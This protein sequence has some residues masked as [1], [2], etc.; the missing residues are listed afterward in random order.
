MLLPINENGIVEVPIL[1][2]GDIVEQEEAEQRLVQQQCLQIHLQL[3]VEPPAVLTF[4]QYSQTSGFVDEYLTLQQWRDKYEN[5]VAVAPVAE[6]AAAHT[7]MKLDAMESE[8]LARNH[9]EPSALISA[10]VAMS[11]ENAMNTT[12]AM[13]PKTVNGNATEA[14]GASNPPVDVNVRPHDANGPRPQDGEPSPPAD[15]KPA[16][17]DD[18]KTLRPDEKKIQTADRLWKNIPPP[19]VRNVPPMYRSTVQ[20]PAINRPPIL[21]KKPLVAPKAAANFPIAMNR[22]RPMTQRDGAVGN[23]RPVT[24]ARPNGVPSNTATRLA[25]RSKTMM[26]LNKHPVTHANAAK[27]RECDGPTNAQRTHD[28]RTEP[29]TVSTVDD[30]GWLTVKTRRRTSWANRFNQPSGYASLPTL[31]LLDEKDGQANGDGKAANNKRENKKVVKSA[32]QKP[33]PT[34]SPKSSTD[35]V[36]KAVDATAKSEPKNVPTK[37]PTDTTAAKRVDTAKQAAPSNKAKPAKCAESEK[38]CASIVSRAT[39]LQRQKSDITGL[40]INTLRK[41][42]MRIEKSKNKQ[43]DGKK[44]LPKDEDE[45]VE[46]TAGLGAAENGADDVK[47]D[48]SDL[49]LCKDIDTMDQNDMTDMDH[50]LND[51]VELESDENQRKL[52]EEQMCLERQILELQNSEIE[53]DTDDADC[54]TILGIEES[55]SNAAELE[56]ACDTFLDTCEEH[57]LETKYRHL[58]SDLSSGERIQTLATLQAFVSRYPGRAQELHQKLSSPSRRRSLHESLKKYQVKQDRAQDMRET[59]SKEKTLRLQVLLARVEDVKSAKQ[60]LIEEKRLRME[61]KLQRYAEN[62]SQYLKDKVRK[63]HD[64]EEKLKEIAFIKELEA[65]NKRLDLL[66]LHKEQEGRLQDLEQERQKRLE[67]KAAKEA[68]VERRR[69]ELAKE[70]QKRLEIIDETRRKREQRVE[71]KQE[72]RDKLRQKIAR[73]KVRFCSHCP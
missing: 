24:A 14:T 49:Q 16:R 68:A 56:E 28:R 29:K 8:F 6:S 9:N 5:N 30:D 45:I 60:K 46:L 13:P 63:A 37:K 27:A 72:E 70:R 64:E 39:I 2:W 15:P 22:S 61:E 48:L 50:E 1:S 34:D 23:R 55:E 26:D 40:K 21:Y 25:A 38:K 43:K 33:A 11:S 12:A 58:L 20:K 69:L 47:L 41:E 19:V 32:P 17:S 31:A 65:Q 52:L 62:R 3:P 51:N 73:E 71:Q 42:Y 10:Q 7:T 4:D 18:D 67:E 54:D 59:L 57:D 36:T 44:A 53:I 35:S 66:E